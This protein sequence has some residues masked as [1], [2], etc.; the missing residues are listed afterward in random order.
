MSLKVIGSGFGRTGTMTTK[1]ALETLGFGPCHHMVE[2]IEHPEQL[3]LWKAVAAGE[4]VDWA[5]VYAGYRSQVDWPGAHVWEQAANAFPNARIIHNERPEEAW[6]NSFSGTIGKFFAVFR[7]LELPPHILDQFTLMHDWMIQGTFT[8]FT[9]RDAAIAAYRANNQRVRETI[10]AER[11]LV[12]HVADGWEPLCE[13]LD[14]PVPDEPFPRS[15]PKK[16]FWE[17]F[18]GEPG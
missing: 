12:F 9:D 13:F 3:R 7:E 1:Q 15:N 2:I 5:E 18:G 10:P 8:D 4:A 16:E 11:L 14:V 17:H 6:W